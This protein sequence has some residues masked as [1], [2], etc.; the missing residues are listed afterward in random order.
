MEEIAIYGAGGMAREVA[1]LIELCNESGAAYETVC[2]IYDFDLEP[3]TMVNGI[4]VLSLNDVSQHFPRAAVIGGIGSPQGRQSTMDKASVAGFNT[5]TIIHPQTEYSRFVDIGEGTVICAGSIL[6]VN[7]AIGRH[8]QINMACTIAHDA[9]I[10]NF[11]TLSPGV[12]IAG[13]VHL[14]QRVFV[15]IGAVIINGSPGK[16]LQIGDD[17]IIGAGACVT[18]SVPPGTTVVGVPAKPIEREF[19]QYC[20]NDF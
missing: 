2:F 12:H 18:K 14:G 7:I 1:W 6:T 4:P 15:G 20:D 19:N 3:G 17:S 9:V 13:R 16:P 10:G 5:A 8:V 11:T